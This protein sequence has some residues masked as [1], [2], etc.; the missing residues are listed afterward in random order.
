MER[1]YLTIPIQHFLG[2]YYTYNVPPQY[3]VIDSIGQDLAISIP[4][5]AYCQ[6]ADAVLISSL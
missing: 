3:F 2:T 1:I 5:K 4:D 6:E